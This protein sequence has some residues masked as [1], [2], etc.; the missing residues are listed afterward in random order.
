MDGPWNFDLANRPSDSRF[1]RSWTRSPEDPDL[2]VSV[3]SDIDLV[4]HSFGSATVVSKQP[5]LCTTRQTNAIG[6]LSLLSEPVPS[7][8]EHAFTSIPVRNVIALDPWLEPLPSPGPSPRQVESSLANSSATPRL[9]VMNSEGFTFWDE[10]FPRLQEIVG[11][12][13]KAFSDESPDNARLLTLLRGKHAAF[14]DFSLLVPFGQQ[15]RDARKFSDLI[16]DLSIAFLDGRFSEELKNKNVKEEEEECLPPTK[17]GEKGKRRYV[18]GF[19]DLVV[20]I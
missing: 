19:G 5:A 9:L 7:L 15:A 18:G 10:H 12:W 16:L 13:K 14:S 6:Q 8:E 17:K 2:K 11:T 1:W 4:G 3:T 20:H